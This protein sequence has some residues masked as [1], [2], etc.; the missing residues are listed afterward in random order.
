[1][2]QL[3]AWTAALRGFLCKIFAVCL[4]PCAVCVLVTQS[5]L[6]LCDPMDCSPPR[7]LCPWGFSRRGHWSGLPCP[8]PGDLPNPGIDPGL[9]HCRWILCQLS[10]QGSPGGTFQ[11]LIRLLVCATCFASHTGQERQAGTSAQP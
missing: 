11:V 7:L 10:Y 8:P 9:P 1:M 2:A 4:V 6:I 5:C 3:S